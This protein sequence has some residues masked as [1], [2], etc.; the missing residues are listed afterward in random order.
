MPV[1]RIKRKARVMGKTFEF[2]LV[3]RAKQGQAIEEITSLVYPQIRD[4]LLAMG[5]NEVEIDFAREAADADLAVMSAIADVQA[6]GFIVER[7]QR[8]STSSRVPVERYNAL[9]SFRR[10][11]NRKK[12]LAA[13]VMGLT[14]ENW[15]GAINSPGHAVQTQSTK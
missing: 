3:F 7:V 11:P 12:L 15:G 13:S 2:T 4:G 6:L 9:L 1:L 14:T 5:D 8:S 10:K